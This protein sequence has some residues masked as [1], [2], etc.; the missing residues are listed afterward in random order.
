M[1]RGGG[2]CGAGLYWEARACC[3]V[4]LPALAHRSRITALPWSSVRAMGVKVI[5]GSVAVPVPQLRAMQFWRAEHRCASHRAHPQWAG[6]K[7]LRQVQGTPAVLKVIQGTQGVGVMI[8]ESVNSAQSVANGTSANVLVQQWRRVPAGHP[9]LYR[10]QG[11]GGMRRQA[12][13]GVPQ[14]HSPGWRG[15]AHRAQILQRAAISAAKALGLSVAGGSAGVAFRAHGHRGELFA[16]W[17]ARASHG[18]QHR[19]HDRDIRAR[20]QGRRR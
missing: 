3:D 6:L 20:P 9:C 4:V 17:R 18:A 16:D 2:R 14:Q 10:R 12:R 13:E 15:R 5:N 19:P 8:V 7:N 11:G 1:Q